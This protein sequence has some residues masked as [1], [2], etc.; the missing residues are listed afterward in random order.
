MKIPKCEH[1][2]ACALGC[3]VSNANLHQ[4]DS[5]CAIFYKKLNAMIMPATGNVKIADEIDAV[6]ETM[7]VN[8]AA[9]VSLRTLKSWSNTLRK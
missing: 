5:A 9:A 4:G 8:G 6:S 7:R 3:R 1:C 2:I